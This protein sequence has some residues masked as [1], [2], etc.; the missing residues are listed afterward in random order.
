MENPAFTA[1]TVGSGDPPRI[2]YAADEPRR[3]NPLGSCAAAREVPITGL[4][5]LF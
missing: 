5:T 3:G 2:D 4:I 1:L